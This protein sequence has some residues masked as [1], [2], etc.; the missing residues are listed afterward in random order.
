MDLKELTGGNT[1]I[2]YGQTELTRDLYEGRNR[3]DG[4]VIHGAEDVKPHDFDTS[5]P[6]LTYRH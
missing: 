3:L 2:V 1:V 5:R 4:I 6:Y